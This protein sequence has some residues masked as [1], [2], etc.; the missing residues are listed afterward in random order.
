MSYGTTQNQQS[1]ALGPYANIM[2][3]QKSKLK[4]I[5]IRYYMK[6]WMMDASIKM[7]SNLESWKIQAGT[8]DSWKTKKTNEQITWVVKCQQISLSIQSV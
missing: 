5:D 7:K 3:K 2:S 1:E 6:F 4:E 8:S